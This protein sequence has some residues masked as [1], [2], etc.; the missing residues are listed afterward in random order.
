MFQEQQLKLLELLKKKRDD[1]NKNK[2]NSKNT[3]SIF[4]VDK[5]DTSNNVEETKEENGTRKI[6]F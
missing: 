2:D 3:G 1:L 5:I 6:N 4:E